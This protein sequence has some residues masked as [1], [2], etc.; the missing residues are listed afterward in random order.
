MPVFKEDGDDEALGEVRGTHAHTC[1]LSKSERE[2]ETDTP[3]LPCACVDLGC[4]CVRGLN[5]RVCNVR[6]GCRSCKG[7]CCNACS[8]AATSRTH[9]HA[10]VLSL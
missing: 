10:L 7:R 3:S 1:T 8:R 4:L 9:T 2:T 5:V 6:V